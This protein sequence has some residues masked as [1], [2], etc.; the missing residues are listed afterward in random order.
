[1]ETEKKNIVRFYCRYCGSWHE[2]SVEDALYHI[3]MIL[4][5]MRESIENLSKEIKKR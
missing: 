4:Q 3:T 1:M 5:Y 2:C